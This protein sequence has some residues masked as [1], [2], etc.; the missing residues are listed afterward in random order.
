MDFVRTNPR[1]SITS[2]KIGSTAPRNQIIVSDRSPRRPLPRGDTGGARHLPA[3]SSPSS[4]SSPRRRRWSPP[5]KAR[6]EWAAVG[7]RLPRRQPFSR[8]SWGLASTAAVRR[9]ASSAGRDPA[10]AC[11]GAVGF[12]A[13]CFGASAWA[14]VGAIGSA[15]RV[16]SGPERA[17]LGLEGLSRRS[18]GQRGVERQCRL[19]VLHLR[20]LLL[21]GALGGLHGAGHR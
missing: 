13:A 9:A 18:A 16:R 6:A 7:P 15:V 14:C 12:C 10:T 1:S 11:V 21:G 2:L 17:D 20:P 19:H 5:G 8:A 3:Q 4:T